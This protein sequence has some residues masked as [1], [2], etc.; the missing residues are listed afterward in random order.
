MRMLGPVLISVAVVYVGL[1]ALLY[2]FQS[3]LIYF[4]MR[5][6]AATP[7]A[8]GLAYEGVRFT[9]EDGTVLDGW[10]IPAGTPRATLLFFHGNAGNISHRLDSLVI[11]HRLGLSTFIFDYRGYGRSEGRPTEEGTYQD[12]MAAWR[13]LTEERG[14]SPEKIVLFGRSLG[15]SVAAWLAARHTPGALIVESTFTS[16]PDF[17]S[18]MYPWLPARWLTRFRYD[19]VKHLSS[20]TCPVLVVHSRDDEIIPVGHGRRLYEAAR[21]PRQFLEIR[22]GHNGG[23]LQS[24]KEYIDGLERFLAAYLRS[25]TWTYRLRS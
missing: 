5:E 8:V 23:F 11:F 25:G 21:E 14:V 22:G 15:G 12:A 1:A 24:G 2:L 7:K 13:Y 9:A 3:R 19:A 17:A 6:I 20:I 16:V 10:F 4:P 18:E